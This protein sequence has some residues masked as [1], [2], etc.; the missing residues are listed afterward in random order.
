MS[1]QLHF[2]LK[3]VLQYIS[4]ANLDGAALLLNQIIRKHPNHSEALRLSA[5]VNAQQ[6]RNEIALVE[7]KKSILADKRNAIAYSNQGNIQLSL[8]ML[9][10]ALASYEMAIKLSPGFPET[11]SNLGNLYQDLKEY[12]KAINC[13]KKA[14]A[15]D[16]N[17]PDYFCNLGNSF[18]KMN[19]QKEA[20]E[21]YDRAQILVPGH[22]NSLYNLALL[23]L[24]NFDFSRG[25]ERYK[26]RW[27]SNNQDSFK[28]I[29]T[30][31]PS[32]DGVKRNNRLFIWSEQGLGDQILYSSM[33]NDLDQYPQRKIISV[34]KKL[35]SIFKRSFPN[36]TVVD[37]NIDI[38]DD[39]YDEQIPIADLGKFF[40]ADIS[41]FKNAKQP[42]LVV[43]DTLLN[44]DLRS[45]INC[46]LSWK[47][48]RVKLGV[49]KSISLNEM[50]EILSLKSINFINLQ[51]GEVIDEIDSINTQF[52]VGIQIVKDIDLYA[53]VDGMLS[54]LNA[55]NLVLT[56]SN[57]TAHL[58][59]AIGKETLLL[60]PYGSSRFWYWQDINGVSLWYPSVKVF[61]QDQ[62]GDWSKPIQAVKAFLENKFGT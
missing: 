42:Y 58:S 50:N 6:G 55:C 51:Y 33:L 27:Q 52:G 16:Q 40:R 62:P 13:Y 34:D 60:L 36:F 57:T 7:I 12:A 21:S 48:E 23:D 49:E 10:E 56:I 14:I 1:Y 9:S 47:S 37:K 25:W 31:K 29:L 53:D 8:G 20:R 22:K 28:P 46:G 15:I 54:I 41:S 24:C 35:V 5:F 2:L 11:Y 59:G 38:S 4:T 26:S 18:L 17:N 61:K 44:H 30:S 32:W 45:V 19:L 3:K 39:D 43:N